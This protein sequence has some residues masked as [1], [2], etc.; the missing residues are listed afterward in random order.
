MGVAGRMLK[1]LIYLLLIIIFLSGCTNILPD[2][3]DKYVPNEQ[4]YWQVINSLNNPEKIAIYMETNFEYSMDRWRSA[5]TP[6]QFWLDGYG[7][8]KDYAVFGTFVARY[9]GYKAYIVHV[10]FSDI[11]DTHLLAIYKE[12]NLY[13]FTDC[14]I[15]WNGFYSIEDCIEWYDYACMY[16][17]S[18][19]CIIN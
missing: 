6:Y 16:K 13:S 5:K 15:Y 19:Y 9:H 2:C 18:G 3:Y 8:C 10:Y 1:R 7:D 17:V 14:W 11:K 4:G 12:G